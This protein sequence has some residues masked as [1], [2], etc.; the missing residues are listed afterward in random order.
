[1]QVGK[2]KLQVEH[3]L[4]FLYVAFPTQSFSVNGITERNAMEKPFVQLVGA[5]LVAVELLKQSSLPLSKA[6]RENIQLS[7]QPIDLPLSASGG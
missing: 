6:L 2:Q 4:V 5:G 7:P 3:D 1:V